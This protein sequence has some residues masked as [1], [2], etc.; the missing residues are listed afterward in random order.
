MPVPTS[1]QALEADLARDLRLLNYPPNGWVPEPPGHRPPSRAR[2]GGCGKRRAVGHICPYECA[3]QPEPPDAPVFGIANLTFRAWY[4]A[5]Y[6]AASLETLGKIPRAMWMDYL[7]WYR[8]RAGLAG[9][10]WRSAGGDPADSPRPRP[11]SDS[12]RWPHGDGG[13]SQADPGDGPGGAGAPA[14]PHGSRLGDA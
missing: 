11:R 8:H 14:Q 13:D 6:G 4:E 7:I 1:L 2:Q 9:R 3:A 5:Q 10:K 12:C